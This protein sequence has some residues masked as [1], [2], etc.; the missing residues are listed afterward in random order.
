MALNDMVES[1]D[2]SGHVL[3]LLAATTTPY[4]GTLSTIHLQS[5]YKKEG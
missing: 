4:R 5:I 3:L 1:L 2:C